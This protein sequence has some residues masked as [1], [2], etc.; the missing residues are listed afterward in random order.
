[1]IQWTKLQLEPPSTLDALDALKRTLVEA[2]KLAFT[3]E[4]VLRSEIPRHL[5]RTS[6]DVVT[7]FLTEVAECVVSHIENE[8]D[9]DTL[10]LFP[11]DFV[12]THPAVWHSRAVNQTFRAVN[13]AFE[14]A[15]RSKDVKIGSVRLATEPEAC[16]QYTMRSA[17][18]NHSIRLKQ[19]EPP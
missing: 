7:D 1:M 17:S 18:E 12:I 8:R 19:V 2:T 14:E 9:R 4:H 16:A 10:N 5:I 13:A 6:V 3:R 15:L 11:I